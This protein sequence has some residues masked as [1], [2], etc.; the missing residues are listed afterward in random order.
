MLQTVPFLRGKESADRELATAKVAFEAALAEVR[1]KLTASLAKPAAEI[2]EEEIEKE[3]EK[4]N[5]ALKDVDGKKLLELRKKVK[6]GSGLRFQAQAVTLTRLPAD[7][8]AAAHVLRGGDP[9]DKVSPVVPGFL[10]AVASWDSPIFQAPTAELAND[11]KQRLRLA[12][13]I[14]SPN[15][16][17]PPRVFVNRIWQQ[18]FGQGIV[19]TAN[20]FGVA[21]GGISHPELLDYLARDFIANGFHVK[22]LQ[23]RLMLSRGYRSATAHP[24]AADC[25]RIDAD[26]RLC[27]RGPFRRLDAEGVRDALLAVSGRLNPDVGGPGFYEALPT[28]V[29]TKYEFFDWPVSAEIE[30]RRRSLYMF[31]RRNLVH[32][33]MEVFDV[34]DANQPCE[35]RR[36]SITAPQ[37]LT[38]LNGELGHEGAKALADRVRREAGETPATQV[39]RAYSLAFGRK[40][41]TTELDLCLKFL[42]ATDEAPAPTTGDAPV[43]E[44]RLTRLCLALLNSNEFLYLD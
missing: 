37:V 30:R 17:V 41:F 21:G 25:A 33:V 3:F 4:K 12:E 32:P 38:L 6:E 27:W 20:D 8:I 31:Q 29:E 18:L 14:A 15:N 42:S 19:T 28:G 23:R 34:A 11:P 35:R 1:E 44:D 40:P 43:V 9:F 5:E 10:T 22:R 7:K 16:P 13:W 24:Q 39:E 2:T 36:P 26:N